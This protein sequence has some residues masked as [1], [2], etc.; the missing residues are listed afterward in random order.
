[1]HVPSESALGKTL[2]ERA[3]FSDAYRAP[4]RRPE[5]GI[6]E[7]FFA[8][9]AHRPVWMNLLLVARN[10]V[11]GFASLETSTTSEILNIQKN[12]RYIVGQKIGPWPIF[13]LGPDELIAGRDNKHM[14]FRV[15]IMKVRNGNGPSVVV[16][17]LCMVHNRFGWYYLSFITPFHK[18]G[19]AQINGECLCRWAPVERISCD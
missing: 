19:F 6:I 13:F 12:D 1:M 16:S 5:A 3:D 7:I 11:A 9:F 4:L 15:S 18:F 10:N 17:T 14:D 2:I 8:I